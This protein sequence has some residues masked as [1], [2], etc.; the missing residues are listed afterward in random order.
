MRVGYK[1]LRF[2]GVVR[3]A[4]QRS[5]LGELESAFEGYLLVVGELVGRDVSL[6]G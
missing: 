3:R 2:V 1:L 6:N 5:A 4:Y